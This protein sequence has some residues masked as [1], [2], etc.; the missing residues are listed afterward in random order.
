MAKRRRRYSLAKRSSAS[1]GQ[2]KKAIAALERLKASTAKARAKAG[3]MVEHVMNTAV[4]A[5]TAFGLGF[6]GAKAGKMP[7]LG[8]VSADV[9]LAVGAH[10]LALLGVGGKMDT[11]LRALGNG[12][13]ATFAVRQGNAV[14]SGA[15]TS[16]YVYDYPAAPE[17]TGYDDDEDDDEDI[18]G[19]ALDPADF[20]GVEIL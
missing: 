18:E 16:G 5:G 12:A 14:G 15:K 4:T 17:L 1:I 19:M 13:L 11:H 7:T 6:W 3:Q 10:L 2:S 8:P 20:A 9:G